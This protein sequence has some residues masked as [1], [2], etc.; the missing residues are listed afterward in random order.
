MEQRCPSCGSTL[1][2]IGSVGIVQAD[3]EWDAQADRFDC[4]QGHTCL[5]VQTE[6]LEDTEPDYDYAGPV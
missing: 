6:R 5:V 2:L 4:E 3:Q 1:T